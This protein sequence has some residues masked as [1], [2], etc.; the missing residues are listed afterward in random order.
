M[1]VLQINAV[2]GMSSTGR[3][4]AEIDEALKKHGI[5]SI[6]ATTQ[7][8]VTRDDIYIVG[9]KIERKLHALFSRITGK[10]AYFSFFA[11]KRLLKWI[12]KEKL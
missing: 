3:T 8:T 2:Y 5:E 10:Q 12:K 4:V 6:V 9:T 7:T 1:K 11:T